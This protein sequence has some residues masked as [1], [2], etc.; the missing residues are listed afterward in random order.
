[1]AKFISQ[2]NP[3]SKG[4]IKRKTAGSVIIRHG[5]REDIKFVRVNG[6]WRR[7]RVDITSERPSVVSSPAVANECS[8][9]MGCRESWAKV[10]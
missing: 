1:M 4:A 7:E 3:I 6:G 8:T 5:G 9:V 10:Y 2:K